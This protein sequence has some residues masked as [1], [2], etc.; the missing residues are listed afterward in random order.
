M[1]LGSFFITFSFPLDE[2]AGF[3]ILEEVRKEM[4]W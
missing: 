1:K 4:S 3:R 2:I